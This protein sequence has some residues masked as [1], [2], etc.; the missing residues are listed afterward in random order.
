M[1]D[2]TTRRHD[3][4]T[5]HSTPGGLNSL[6]YWTTARS[7]LRVAMQYLVIWL[8]RI[9]PSLRLKNWLLRRIGVTVGRGVSWGLE[10]T[11]DVFWPDLIT[12]EDHAII[13]Y[14]ATILCHEF[15]QDEYRTG[16]VVIG[17][18][19]MIGA[20]AVIL[21]GVEI[22]AGAQVAANSLVTRDVPPGETVA[23]VPATA[24]SSEEVDSE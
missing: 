16:E 3:R 10:S 12:V 24:M 19:A 7:P 11:P 20:G 18:R 22:G 6:Q 15:L 2:D 17:E 21:P 14:N 9:N 8:V 13:G 23:G 4:I 1:S 5:H